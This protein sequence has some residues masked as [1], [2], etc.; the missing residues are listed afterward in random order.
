MPWNSYESLNLSQTLSR[1]VAVYKKDQVRSKC[2]VNCCPNICR[3]FSASYPEQSAV[4][5]SGFQERSEARSRKQTSVTQNILML[6]V[7]HFRKKKKIIN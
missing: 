3:L 5:G 4:C 6:V 2:V 7:P 1:D